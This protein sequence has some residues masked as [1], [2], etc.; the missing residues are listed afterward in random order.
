MIAAWNDANVFVVSPSTKTEASL[1]GVGW[2]GNGGALW[3]D[4]K[5]LPNNQNAQQWFGDPTVVAI[6]ATHFVVGSL[7]LPR[8]GAG[9]RRDAPFRRGNV[10]SPFE[11]PRRHVERDWRRLTGQRRRRER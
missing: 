4:L 5:G 2:S 1:T 9:C 10:R 11:E 7:Y 3:H 6:D 8:L